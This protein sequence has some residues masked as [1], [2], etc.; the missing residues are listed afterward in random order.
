MKG[1]I[2]ILCVAYA[3][4]G[5]IENL[6]AQF[7]QQGSNVHIRG[8]IL[9]SKTN[10]P[11]SFA[12]VGY[13][14]KGIGTVSNKAGRFHLEYAARKISTKDLLQI[15]IIGY[16]TQRFTIREITQLLNARESIR[17]VPETYSLGE[18]LVDSEVKS[19]RTTTIGNSKLED[20]R[21]GYWKNKKGLGGE[22]AT[23]IKVRHKGT[24]I[25]QL[26][27]KVI[28]NL[29]DSL[30]VRVNIYD[31][32]PVYLTPRNNIVRQAIY[33][34]ITTKKGKETIPLTEYGIQVND[35]VI[36]SLELIQVY[37]NRIGLA[38]ACSSNKRS[39]FIKR[40]SQDAWDIRKGE[41]MAFTLD[42]TYPETDEKAIT[43][44]VKPDVVELYWDASA[45]AQQ[46]NIDAEMELLQ[47]YFKSLK[48]VTVN[49][50]KFAQGY[51]EEETFRVYKGKSDYIT[52]YLEKTVYEGESDY[53]RLKASETRKNVVNLVFTD[54]RGIFSSLQPVFNKTTFAISSSELVHEDALKNLSLFADGT[55]IDLTEISPKGGLDLLLRDIPESELSKRKDEVEWTLQGTLTSEMGVLPGARITNQNSG[56][57]A[58]SAAK[59]TFKIQAGEDHVLKISYPGMKT[60]LLTVSDGNELTIHMDTEGDWLQEVILEGKKKE[61]M[62]ETAIGVKNFDAVGTKLD[63]IT[64][65]DIKPHH[66]RLE[67][68]LAQEPQLLIERNPYTGDVVYSFP[69]TR[70]M[71][72]N[73][74]LLPIIV[75][76]GSI[77]QQSLSALSSQAPVNS[78]P[79]IDVQN[80]SS[81]VTTSSLAAVTQYGSVAAGGAIIIKTKSLDPNYK[82][83][84][85]A[86]IDNLLVQGNGYDEEVMSLDQV[87]EKPAY[88]I[89]LE[90][91]TSF[92]DALTIYGQYRSGEIGR[93]MNF[94]LEASRY[95]RKWDEDKSNRILTTISAQSPRDV[96]VLRVLA[97]ELETQNKKEK[98]VKLYEYISSLAPQEIQSYRDLALA[99]QANG[100]YSEA[101]AMYKQM[102]NNEIED[103]DFKPLQKT[104]ENELLHLLAFHKSK[105]TFQDLPNSLLD[106][107]FKKDRRL[108]FE[109]TDSEAEFEI[110]FVNPQGKFFKWA[111]TKLENLSRI[112][113]EFAKGYLM[114]EFAL[115]DAPPGE[116]LINLVYINDTNNSKPVYLKYT[117][118]Q[119][120]ATA[121]QT[122]AIKIINL[123]NH[124]NKVTLGK[125]TLN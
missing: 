91:A 119:N 76:D 110:Q 40:S 15:S 73:T 37:G 39:S 120:Y 13:M 75:V 113:D 103:L 48:N 78:I 10:K 2:T 69:R 86:P 12:N 125:I 31:I 6:Q 28:E 58:V 118:Y 51:Y 34:T 94:L 11:I 16:V 18:V 71:S 56:L 60:R 105:V 1:I 116:W 102:L 111:H 112:Q 47:R 20:K 124:E 62:V 46:R 22:L 41:A 101:F 99:Y 106:T 14:G 19:Y 50:H 100:Q 115:D 123:A 65:K 49:V 54:G 7:T 97:Y 96:E 109:W 77:Y 63:L 89:Q 95:F 42:I 43:K 3:L 23:W 61:E 36:V 67:D 90:A 57:T 35:D 80:I 93:S 25:E 59:G 27:I 122:K 5:T 72:P 68:I 70:Y 66:M 53:A 64:H 45:K 114:E 104:I 98:L 26:H 81:I 83:I 30:L 29:S 107:S 33:H 55:N 24:K 85:K 117:E 79:P 87:L 88:S 82:G 8:L 121:E 9:D 4:L 21:F 108:L 92:E 74:P 32:D 52:D 44:R 38:L 84:A 17:L